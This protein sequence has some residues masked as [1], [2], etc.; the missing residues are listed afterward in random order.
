M[1]QF[2]NIIFIFVE[3]AFFKCALVVRKRAVEN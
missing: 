3:I 2:K 1:L